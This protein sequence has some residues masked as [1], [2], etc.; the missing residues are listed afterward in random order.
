[1]SDGL[2]KDA[3]EYFRKAGARGGR[4]GQ[5]KLSAAERKERARLAGIASGKARRKK[6]KQK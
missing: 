3:K 1:M 2:S 6:S 5:A 4:M